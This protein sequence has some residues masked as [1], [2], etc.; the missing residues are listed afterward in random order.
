MSP[1][2]DSADERDQLVSRIVDRS[3]TETDWQEF[4]RVEGLGVPVRDELIASRA[5]VLPSFG[6]G[7][8]VVIME[9]LA[10]GRP[11]ISTC[12]AAI[13][14]LVRDGETGWLV[15]PE[16]STALARAVREATNDPEE[17]RRRGENGRRRLDRCF[18][19]PQAASIW[20]ALVTGVTGR[21]DVGDGAGEI[22]EFEDG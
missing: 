19:P 7:L 3:E 20:H 6:E 18:R 15:P 14:E 17:A 5:L 4:D 12:I 21:V 8:P 22:K 9:A 11:V 16:N 1:K 2:P 13:P 10:L